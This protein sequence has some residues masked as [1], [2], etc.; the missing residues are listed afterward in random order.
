MCRWWWRRLQACGFGNLALP[1]DLLAC[2]EANLRMTR[3]VQDR[4]PTLAV[5]TSYHWR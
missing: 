2:R 5:G 3:S 1:L 4:Q